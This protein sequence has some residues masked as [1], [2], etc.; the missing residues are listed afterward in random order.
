MA[1]VAQRVDSITE[2]GLDNGVSLQDIQLP[3]S[4]V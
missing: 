3:F 2:V 1:A 4:S